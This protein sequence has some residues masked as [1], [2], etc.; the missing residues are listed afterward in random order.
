MNPNG[1]STTAYFQYG[2]SQSNLSSTVGT[3]SIGNGN[4]SVNVSYTLSGL[5]SNTTYYYRIVGSNG[6]GTN[7]GGIFSFT[8]STSSINQVP[9]ISTNGATNIT[10]NSVTLNGSV[11]PNGSSTTAYFQYGTSQSNLS[12]TVGTQSI[13]NGNSSV[14]VSYTLSG[15]SSNTTYYY[16]IV[17]SNGVGIASGSTISFATNA[18][19]N[20]NAPTAITSVVTLKT[21]TSAKL[22]GLVII[23]GNIS[24]T[25]WFEY[26]TTISLGSKTHDHSIGSSPSVSFAHTVRGLKLD[27]VYYFRAVAENEKGIDRGD[28]LVFKTLESSSGIISSSSTEINTNVLSPIS[29][30]IDS[31]FENVVVGDVVAY[32]VTYKNIS[33]E[34]LEKAIL[35]VILPKEIAFKKATTGIFS[36]SDNTLTIEI[37]TLEKSDEGSVSLQGEILGKAARQELLVTTAVLVYSDPDSGAQEDVIAYALHN[38]EKNKNGNLLTA[39]ALFGGSGFPNSLL[40]W[41]ILILILIGFVLLGRMFY[42]KAQKDQG[43]KGKPSGGQ[44]IEEEPQESFGAFN[45]QMGQESKGPPV[46][47]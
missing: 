25:A 44:G 10:E 1:S 17:G 38:M 39:A 6:V 37:G 46:I 24:T 18:S 16:R 43:G 32:T 47:G 31:L 15:L 21:G 30:S 12:S 45:A 40:E 3:Q 13:G 33:K 19:T 42:L 28:I 29:L 23:S 14:N 4:S 5:S 34:K 26:G 22:N 35:R 20:D 36:S 27:T 9:T 8:T 11:N 7:N 41:I 2:T